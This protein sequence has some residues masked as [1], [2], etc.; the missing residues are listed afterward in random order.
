MPVNLSIKNVPD[1]V[2]RALRTRAALNQRS[3]NEEL[4]DVLKQVAKDQGPVSIDGLLAAQRRKPGLE[5]TVTKVRAAQEEEHE[6]AARRFEDLLGSSDD[7]RSGGR[8]AP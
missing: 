8:T 7:P 6:K 4:L 3:L 2:A 1:E 5:E